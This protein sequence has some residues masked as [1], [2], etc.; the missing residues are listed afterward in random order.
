MK[1]KIH[2]GVAAEVASAKYRSTEW[3]AASARGLA[4]RTQG[5][6]RQYAWRAGLYRA[7]SILQRGS[8]FDARNRPF[9]RQQVR[10]HFR[11]PHVV[12]KGFC[13]KFAAREL[14]NQ[15]SQLSGIIVCICDHA[16]EHGIKIEIFSP[17]FGQ[18]L[19]FNIGQQFLCS[20][21]PDRQ[22]IGR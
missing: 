5:S 4:H 11:H 12:R 2:G 15:T 18:A 14:V 20:A 7:A 1:K 19:V 10:P 16:H 21:S 8:G 6:L 9:K 22:T 3:T 17:A 13:L